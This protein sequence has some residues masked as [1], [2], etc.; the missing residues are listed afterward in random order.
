MA[1][2]R[3]SLNARK[4]SKDVHTVSTF[5][6]PGTFTKSGEQVAVGNGAQRSIAA[7]TRLGNSDD[8]AIH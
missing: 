8:S 2:S 7:R 1:S 6:P 5:P 3:K 4:W